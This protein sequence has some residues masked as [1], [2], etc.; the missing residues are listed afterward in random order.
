MTPG[1]EKTLLKIIEHFKHK[2]NCMLKKDSH[3]T[4][5]LHYCMSCFSKESLKE[6]IKMVQKPKYFYRTNC[7]GDTVF[8]FAAV[9]LNRPEEKNISTDYSCDSDSSEENAEKCEKMKVKNQVIDY[10]ETV[11]KES[12]STESE[13]EEESDKEES[14][15]DRCA[16]WIR[17]ASSCC[18]GTGS[19]E[20]RSNPAMKV[21][22]Q[23]T[24]NEKS[25]NKESSSKESDN[26]EE[27]ESEKSDEEESFGERCVCWIRGASSCCSG[28]VTPEDRSNQAA[29]EGQRKKCGNESQGKPMPNH[30]TNEEQSTL[31]GLVLAK[32]SAHNKEDTEAESAKK[33][34]LLKNKKDQTVL[35]LAAMHASPKELSFLLKTACNLDKECLEA[36]DKDGYNFC[37]YAVQNENQNDKIV[38]ELLSV[39]DKVDKEMVS[40]LIG[41]YATTNEKSQKTQKVQKVQKAQRLT[42]LQRAID[43]KS[44]KDQTVVKIYKKLKSL[45]NEGKIDFKKYIEQRDK[46]GN[47]AFILAAMSFNKEEKKHKTARKLFHCTD[48]QHWSLMN[49]HGKSALHLAFQSSKFTKHLKKK[50]NELISESTLDGDGRSCLFYACM[51]WNFD[52]LLPKGNGFKILPCTD[53]DKNTLLHA[54]FFYT[55][56]LADDSQDGPDKRAE[57][58]M[59]VF[60]NIASV[61]EIAEENDLGQNCLHASTLTEDTLEKILS[62]AASVGNEGKDSKEDNTCLVADFR[63]ELKKLLKALNGF[64]AIH[65]FASKYK[66]KKVAPLLAKLSDSPTES[67]LQLTVSSG[68]LKGA[69]CLHFACETNNE[70]NIK[71]LMRRRNWQAL[72]A[73]T[74]SGLTALDFAKII[75][76]MKVVDKTFKRQEE[77]SKLEILCLID[78]VHHGLQLP[79]R[80]IAR[81]LLFSMLDKA[82]RDKVAR[83]KDSKQS[84][85]IGNVNV[86]LGEGN[87]DDERTDECILFQALDLDSPIMF[88]CALRLKRVTREVEAR[89]WDYLQHKSNNG[90]EQIEESK[91]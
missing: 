1:G 26:E 37:H 19:S 35:H 40:T 80:T 75:S 4:T 58:F 9:N 49:N 61:T 73:A 78:P 12:S 36:Q 3:R 46:C 74:H 77:K 65:S 32:I 34:L 44:C 51:G 15:G 50:H 84:K 11:N 88:R 13:S 64:H 57:N 48:R 18:S 45:G 25:A 90:K 82:S 27:S 2:K 53:F 59:E 63:R 16:R 68:P 70:E 30:K 42:L 83:G 62:K 22:N 31:F 69:T 55:G 91:Q 66:L 89:L 86:E 8:H 6:I 14:F 20:D 71:W 76:R 23:I 56:K 21:N 38:D 17:G 81:Q 7:D 79:R 29:N 41:E 52:L 10:Q 39:L 72:A 33:V 43:S 54:L 85:F 87:E 24:N 28:T 5:P 67:L 60:L 47:T